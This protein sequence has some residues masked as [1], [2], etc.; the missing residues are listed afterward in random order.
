MQAWP[1]GSLYYPFGNASVKST[2]GWTSTAGTHLESG[3]GELRLT[4]E[5]ARLE[6]VSPQWEAHYLTGP[7][8]LVVTGIWPQEIVASAELALDNGNNLSCTLLAAGKVWHVACSRQPQ[9]GGCHV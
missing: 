7:T 6:L 2:D 4:G 5:G 8:E 1:V 9:G 3:Y